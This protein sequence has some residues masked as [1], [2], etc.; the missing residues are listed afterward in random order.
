MTVVRSAHRFVAFLFLVA[1]VLGSHPAQAKMKIESRMWP[2]TPEPTSAAS[3]RSIFEGLTP[4]GAGY[5]SAEISGI[6]PSG[7]SVSGSIPGGS[8]SN[9]GVHI[10]G[11]FSV[12]PG[13]VG[14]WT[15]QWGVDFMGGGV[16]LID[17][18]SIAENWTD[19]MWWEG[20]Y[21][22]ASGVLSGTV[23]LAQGAH[24]IELFGFEDCCDGAM[25]ARFKIGAG[26]YQDLNDTNLPSLVPGAQ[27]GSPPL[28]GEM[29]TPTG[30][31]TKGT[32]SSC[33]LGVCDT[34]DSLCGYVT[35]TSCSAANVCR[36]GACHVDGKCGLPNGFEC[37]AQNQCRSNL[38]DADG[39][40]GTPNGS[41][42]SSDSACRSLTCTSGV[43][44]IGAGTA[45]TSAADCASGFCAP[46]GKCGL[47]NSTACT[48]DIQCR[49]MICNSDGSCGLGTGASC[50]SGVVCRSGSCSGGTCAPPEDSGIVDSGVSVED[51]GG[52]SLGDASSSSVDGGS[53]GP[54]NPATSTDSGTSTNGGANGGDAGSTSNTSTEDSGGGGCTFHA[55]HGFGGAVVLWGASA[56]LVQRR[57]RRVATRR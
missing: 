54:S 13:Q 20:N 16:L 17:G 7:T 44:G 9:Y 3:A 22:T 29:C 34:S 33:Y 41:A 12:A 2:G 19:D 31:G 51:A 38:C 49:S 21:N 10:M 55:G 26:A 14:S 23:S 28:G 25:G 47:A 8:A 18:V 6:V 52:S 45:C 48:R 15:F 43:C 37:T 4:G 30:V 50:A 56:L 40:C 1:A 24:L 32:A 11:T 27:F 39:R 35:G 5:G 57:R 53:V 46:D 36:N 42:C